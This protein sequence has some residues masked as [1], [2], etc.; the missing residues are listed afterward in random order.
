MTAAA[1]A[2]GPH[3]P[4]DDDARRALE[5]A[6]REPGRLHH[7]CSGKHA[8]MMLLCADRS[9]WLFRAARVS[10]RSAL[11]RTP[12]IRLGLRMFPFVFR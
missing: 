2:C 3:P 5:E 11:V 6:G 10:V 12:M 9:L 8:G 7:N 1:L 4:F